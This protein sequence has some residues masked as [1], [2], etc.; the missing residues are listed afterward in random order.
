MH[1][2]GPVEKSDLRRIEELEILLKNSSCPVQKKQ[3]EVKLAEAKK[4]LGR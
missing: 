3:A 2:Q 1:C 4:K